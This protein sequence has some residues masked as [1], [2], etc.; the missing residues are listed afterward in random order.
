MSPI[1]L[2]QYTLKKETLLWPDRTGLRGDFE[3]SYLCTLGGT[4]EHSSHCWNV[5]AILVGHFPSRKW[6]GSSGLGSE[7]WY[8]VAKCH[9]SWFLQVIQRRHCNH[10]LCAPRTLHPLQRHPSIRKIQPIYQLAFVF[11]KRHNTRHKVH[12]LSFCGQMFSPVCI[13]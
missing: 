8:L 4:S 11:D 1:V 9:C 6:T 10:D 13:F 2:L 5:V 12:C 3:Y 7:W